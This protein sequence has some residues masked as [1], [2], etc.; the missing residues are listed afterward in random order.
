[1]NIPPITSLHTFCS[2]T[3]TSL[4][5]AP[6]SKFKPPS[7]LRVESST[8]PFIT[9]YFSI[10]CRA[11]RNLFSWA[12][13]QESSL[14]HH[15]IPLF[16]LPSSDFHL[17][18]LFIMSPLPRATNTLHKLQMSYILNSASDDNR[19]VTNY[20]SESASP[21][22]LRRQ[23]STPLRATRDSPT[24]RRFECK[25]CQFRF[26]LKGDLQKHYNTVH[27]RIKNHVC[28]IC[29]A[30]FGEKGNLTKHEKRH[31][32]VKD[33]ECSVPGCSKSFV[34]RDGLARHEQCVH[35]KMPQTSQGGRGSHSSLSPGS[36]QTPRSR[37]WL[38]FLH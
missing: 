29:G 4:P 9:I 24:E 22:T 32:G 27:L 20:D 8:H 1:M 7:P 12:S 26:R 33:F 5:N 17:H 11:T 25:Q 34:L 38:H 16:D 37:K 15:L 28:K 3:F 13:Q 2:S 18:V 30:R 31:E 23:A 6:V 10:S 21:A 14:S 19:K 36:F 35:K